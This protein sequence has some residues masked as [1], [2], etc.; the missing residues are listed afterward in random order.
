MK[1]VWFFLL[2]FSIN[3]FAQTNIE[4]FSKLSSPEKWWVVFHPFKAKKAMKISKDAI[5]VTDSIKQTL[6]LDKD[7]NGG[8]LDAFK[9]SFWM[10]RL[11][12][13]IG[14]NAALS[15]GIAHEKGNY[16]TYK[17]GK[18]EDGLLPDKP[19]SEMDLFNNKVGVKIGSENNF[20]SREK[21]T[22]IVISEIKNGKMKIIKKDNQG[23]FLTCDGKIISKELI[24][25]NWE[26]DKCLIFSN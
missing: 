16:K 9:H 12:Q 24:K 20:S 23:N 6:L 17:K 3:S 8:K 21:I 10:A 19:S 7:K 15:L 5:Q 22:E 18:L 2:L 11:S 4:S 25:G 1:K 14:K 13:K 26:N